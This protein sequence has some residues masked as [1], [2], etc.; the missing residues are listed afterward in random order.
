MKSTV[1]IL[2]LLLLLSCSQD[3]VDIDK[4]YLYS[5]DTHFRISKFESLSGP[6][7][8]NNDEMPNTDILKELTFYLSRHEHDLQ[9]KKIKDKVVIGSYEFLLSLALPHQYI[10]P[11][12]SLV[13]FVRKGHYLGFVPETDKIIK[14]K[15]IDDNDNVALEFKK[16][17]DKQYQLLL[18]KKYH[19]F[20]TTSFGY[21]DF[22][23]IFEK[24]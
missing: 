24:F 1:L 2:S 22:K 19:D 16:I 7:D 6:I 5:E 23:I 12:S 11:D 13:S 15:V 14:N 3:D 9:V 4:K 20:S 8:L 17:N 21:Y 18:R 10:Y